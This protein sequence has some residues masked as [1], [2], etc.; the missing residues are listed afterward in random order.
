MNRI[1]RLVWIDVLKG[2][3]I[4]YVTFAHLYPTLPIE[5]HIYSFH[6]FLFFFISGFL[7][8]KPSD[9]ISFIQKKLKNLIIPFLFWNIF[10]TLIDIFISHDYINPIQHMLTINGSLC[11]NRPIWFLL[12]LFFVEIIFLYIDK[13]FSNYKYLFVII[14][15]IAAYFTQ[16]TS[17]FLKLTL[18]PIA[19]VYY[20]FGNISNA[21][22]SKKI[23]S[24]THLIMI[25]ALFVNIYTSVILNSRIS[26]VSAYFG[27][28][29][30]CLIAGISGIIFYFLLAQII[31]FKPLVKLL[32]YIGKNS[33][34]IMCAQYF[35]FYIYSFI[36]HK[37][38]D[39]PNIWYLR[40]TPKAFIL[41]CI[42]IILICLCSEFIKLLKSKTINTIIGIR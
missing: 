35:L 26:V 5:K 19:F 15:F 23:I 31:T 6:M 25:L 20:S 37:F 7:Y 38:F 24:K 4:F 39:I 42:T 29:Y 40:N 17:V 13:I 2:I 10:A 8:K 28:Y 1:N 22:Y 12:I 33:M 16:N 34:I 30:L 27:N 32:E 41:T 18:V 3:G 14:A 21:I 9:T 36:F 11:W